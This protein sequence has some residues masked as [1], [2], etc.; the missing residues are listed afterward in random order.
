MRLLCLPRFPLFPVTHLSWIPLIPN[1]PS[2]SFLHSPSSLSS[3]S[4]L[5][6]FLPLLPPVFPPL[7]PPSQTSLRPC[8]IKARGEAG[9]KP[10]IIMPA[11]PAGTEATE[12]ENQDWA[13]NP[14]LQPPPHSLSQAQH[15][16]NPSQPIPLPSSK[17]IENRAKLN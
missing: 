15:H 10:I 16:P 12:H 11:A 8:H 7:S 3:S 14:P 13:P 6:S 5:S 9:E 1:P 4:L 2:S 17:E